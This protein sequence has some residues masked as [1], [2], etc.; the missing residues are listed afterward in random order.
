VTESAKTR[1]FTIGHGANDRDTLQARLQQA[2]IRA[3]VD[4]R[5]FPRSRR[6]PDVHTEALAVWLPAI[7]ISY[8]WDERL[9]GRRTLGRDEPVIDSWWQ[10]RSFQAYAA[11]T[12]TEEFAAALAEL[13]ASAVHGHTVVMCSENVWWRCH[14]RLIADVATL[15]H[16]ID[17]EHLMPDGR[18]VPHRPAD[19][20]RLIDS[21]SQVVWDDHS[22]P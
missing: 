13:V 12:R 16:H 9:G 5:R 14:R 22:D 19:G 8:R 7:G 10:V 1:L 15:V 17:V 18:A 6:N 21:G 3:L 11:H 4:V 2:E 20:A